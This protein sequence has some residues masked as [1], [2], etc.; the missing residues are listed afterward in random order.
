LDERLGSINAAAQHLGTTWPSLRK[1]FTRHGLGMPERNPE[2]VRQRAIAAACR[3]AGQPAAPPLDPAFLALNGGQL[4]VRRG[5]HAEQGVR[6][7]RAEEI[8][9]LSY[10]T[11]VELNAGSRLPPR[12]VGGHHHPP[13]RTRPTAGRRAGRP[14][15]PPAAPARRPHRPQPTPEP[16]PAAAAGEGDTCR[17]PIGRPCPADQRPG[18]GLVPR[19][20]DRLPEQPVPPRTRRP[21]GPAAGADPGG[22]HV[23]AVAAWPGVGQAPRGLAA[24]SAAPHAAGGGGRAARRSPATRTRTAP[25]LAGRVPA[26]SRPARP[27]AAQRRHRRAARGRG[28]VRL[29]RPTATQ[30]PTASS[31]R[32][33]GAAVTRAAGPGPRPRPPLIQRPTARPGTGPGPAAGR[34]QPLTPVLLRPGERG[35]GNDSG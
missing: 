2:A 24:A 19:R 18:R 31:G 4:P 16:A 14:R 11:V 34:P 30:P 3:H 25:T 8:E 7:R 23:R 29:G 35:R 22:V 20:L 13:P 28:P 6:L 33:G 9:T 5:P 27:P 10:R 26:G 12:T 1:A 17:C 32:A 21:A 15:R